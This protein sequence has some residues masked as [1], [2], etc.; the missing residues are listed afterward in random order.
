MDG[1]PPQDI[2]VIF[3]IML[4]NLLIVNTLFQIKIKKKL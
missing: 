2:Q 3:F 1:F 4:S